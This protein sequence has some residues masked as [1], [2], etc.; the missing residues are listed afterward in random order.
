MSKLM[1]S[2]RGLVARALRRSVTKRFDPYNSHDRQ[3]VEFKHEKLNAWRRDQ[4][5]YTFA[6]HITA[7][8]EDK[9]NG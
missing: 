2:D 8:M 5:R 7:E 1:M 9:D 4:P 6:E 3:K